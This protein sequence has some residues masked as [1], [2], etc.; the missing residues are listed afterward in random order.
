MRQHSR[1]SRL[2]SALCAA[3]LLVT[4]CG[5]TQPA[6]RGGPRVA[7]PEASARDVRGAPPPLDIVLAS[8]GARDC[9]AEH[10]ACFERCWN[11]AP[12]YPRQQGDKGHHNYCTEKCRKEYTR[13]LEEVGARPLAFPSMKTALD[14]LKEHKTEVL[15]GSVVIVAG[16]AFV[17]ST[18]GA[19]ALVLVPLAA[20]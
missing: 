3:S 11:R 14:W 17:V 12:P 9:D 6:H 20:L 13:C 16:A 19:G 8:G 4:A 2:G 1:H 5:G 7:G 15:V 10:I 18:G